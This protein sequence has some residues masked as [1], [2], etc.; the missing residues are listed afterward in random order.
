MLLCVL[1]S[2]PSCAHVKLENSQRLM[3]RTD[4][5][6]AAE[7]APDWVTDALLTI[8]QLEYEIERR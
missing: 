3:D 8:D 6:Q 2:M 7:A 5:R 1:V 4:F